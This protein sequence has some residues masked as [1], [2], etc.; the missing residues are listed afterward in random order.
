LAS[1]DSYAAQVQALA[2]QQGTAPEPVTPVQDTAY[3]RFFQNLEANAPTVEEQTLP[4]GKI[5]AGFNAS[6]GMYWSALKSGAQA[7]GMDVPEYIQ[8]NIDENMDIASSANVEDLGDQLLF[9]VGQL[10]P[11]VGGV[12]AGAVLAPVLGSTMALG[13]TVGGVLSGMGLTAGDQQL[14]AEEL[15]PDHVADY[16]QLAYSGAL[17]AGDAYV[18]GKLR[19]GFAPMKDLIKATVKGNL[20]SSKGLAFAGDVIK[21]AATTGAVEGVQ[22]LGTG[23]G[24]NVFTGQDIDESRIET[25]AESARDEMIIGGILGIPAGGVNA[26]AGR[27][28]QAQIEFDAAAKLKLEE[29]GQSP[30]FRDKKGE[31]NEDAI[32]YGPAPGAVKKPHFFTM[33]AANLTGNAFDPVKLRNNTNKSLHALTRQFVQTP[34]ERVVGQ[35][36]IPEKAQMA[37]ADGLKAGA[38]FFNA[39]RDEQQIAWDLKAKGELDMS[40]PVHAGLHKV[41]NELIPGHALIAGRGKIDLADGLWSDPNYL[42]VH[43]LIDMK[44]VAE[45]PTAVQRAVDIMKKE[46]KSDGLIEKVTNIIEKMKRD[47]IEHGNDMHYGHDRRTSDAQSK[48]IAAMT[49]A[50]HEGKAAKVRGLIE[51]MGKEY[52]AKQR[53][54]SA[55]LQRA[56]ADLGQEWYSPYYKKNA[57]PSE[58]VKVHLKK[59]SEALAHIDSFG[60]ALEKFDEG[61]AR[62]IEEGDSIGRPLQSKDITQLYDGLRSSQR[63]HLNPI[64]QAMRDRQQKARATV[65][66]LTLGLSALVSIPEAINIGLQT[67]MKS[68]I[69]S[70]AKTVTPVNKDKTLIAAEDIGLS[71]SD[72]HSM[73]ARTGEDP[74]DIGRVEGRFFKLTGLPR[75]Q[76]FLSVWGAKSQDVYIR[77]QL[78]QLKT[79][80]LSTAETNHFYRKLSSA[81]I[82]IGKAT[83]WA[84]SGYS[85]S[86]LYFRNEY[87]PRLYGLTRDTIVEPT[88]VDKPLWQNDERFLLISQ[89]KGFMTAFTNRVMRGTM[90]KVAAEG[91]G[92]NRDLALRLAPYTAMYLVGQMGVGMMRDLIKDGELQEDRTLEERVWNAFGYLGAVAYGTDAV[93]SIMS[94]SDPLASAFGPAVGI[95]LGLVKSGVTG[96]AEISPDPVIEEII[97]RGIPNAPAAGGIREHLNEMYQEAF[98]GG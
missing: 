71:L 80:T 16:K 72:L 17:G 75:L 48:L 83:Q 3:E 70:L 95:T 50:R 86:D 2:A 79:G 88:G 76:Y 14:K 65:N 28:S 84:E 22:D 24:A 9:A 78:D 85:K 35:P 54:S 53:Q 67:D 81:G 43:E 12:A 40:N 34:N 21:T 25:L 98:G 89:L 20:K 36:T 77:R 96:V 8:K 26:M 46:G 61:V 5:E 6:Q 64:S 87:A 74:F 82:D 66:I 49:D 1:P 73:V 91:P 31:I 51:K 56:L 97:R 59:T 29:E 7:A 44:A 11:A 41:L 90:Q 52:S 23:I 38:D 32:S 42:P 39:S 92:R 27:L 19:V 68:A 60:P 33:L 57:N 13:A 30:K 55:T 69:K 47:F 15:D 94:R 62:A 4:V 58:M 37:Y 63:I 45:D 93:N 18:L 10:G